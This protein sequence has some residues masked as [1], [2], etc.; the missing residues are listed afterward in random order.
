MNS[1]NINKS[2]PL[3]S[4]IMPVYN[5]ES[6]VGEAIE[7]ILSQSFTN[8]E[9][10]ILDDCSEDR[11]LA[12]VNSFND[13]RLKVYN[14]EKNIGLTKSLNK[15]IMKSEG[16]YIARQDGDD[17]SSEHRFEKQLNFIR[18]ENIEICTSRAIRKNT[19]K[20]IP[21][22]SY[23]V[24]KNLAMKYKNPF[25]HGTLFIKKELLLEIGMYDERF[26]YSQ[27]YKLF[28]DLLNANL[29][30]KTIKEPLYVLNMVDNISTNKKRAQK[31]YAD[32]VRKNIAPNYELYENQ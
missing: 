24:P 3:I 14:N 30:I 15:L 9:F 16:S 11:T 31:Y 21:N 32:C 28:L 1:K 10:L 4:V 5:C 22:L 18:K 2:N 26:V 27:D 19:S 20:K 29:K 17:T 6:S 7:S 23:Y 25:I 12:K 8:F 13:P